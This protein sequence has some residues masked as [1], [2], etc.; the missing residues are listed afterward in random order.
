MTHM[1]EKFLSWVALVVTCGDT[2]FAIRVTFHRSLIW[3]WKL[4]NGWQLN[5]NW[6]TRFRLKIIFSF[7]KIWRI[8][9]MSSTT[10]TNWKKKLFLRIFSPLSNDYPVLEKIISRLAVKWKKLT[11]LWVAQLQHAVAT[12]T[13]RTRS[14]RESKMRANYADY[15]WRGQHVTSA[16]PLTPFDSRSN[17]LS[18]GSCGTERTCPS[19]LRPQLSGKKVNIL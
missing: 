4:K 15:V 5:F 9:K 1:G 3:Q 13:N 8:Q 10:V 11:S 12:V 18:P 16:A 7:L 2:A 17:T 14:G 19:S 6:M